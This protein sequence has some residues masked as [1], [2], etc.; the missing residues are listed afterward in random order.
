LLCAA[1]SLGCNEQPT[2]KKKNLITTAKS[3]DV[4]KPNLK[5][6]KEKK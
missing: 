3:K 5:I 1:I 4:V 2:Q 6:K